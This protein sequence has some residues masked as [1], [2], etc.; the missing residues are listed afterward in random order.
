MLGGANVSIPGA[1]GKILG[2][3]HSCDMAFTHASSYA[4]EQCSG[5]PPQPRAFD[6]SVVLGQKPKQLYWPW[7]LLGFV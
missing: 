4:R 6:V 1:T 2:Y 7:T 5:H 3:N